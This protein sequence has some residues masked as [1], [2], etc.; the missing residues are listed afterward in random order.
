MPSATFSSF[1]L[2][3]EL[4]FR[5]INTSFFRD[6]TDFLWVYFLVSDRKGKMLVVENT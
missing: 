2:K 5:G 4:L 3:P 6:K 1:G